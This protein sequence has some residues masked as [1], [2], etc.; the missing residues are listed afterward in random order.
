M[1]LCEE[2]DLG[3]S[4]NLLWG[5]KGKK[6]EEP[7]QYPVGFEPTASRVKAT[8]ACTLLLCYNHCPFLMESNFTR[9]AFLAP[10]PCTYTSLPLDGM[11]RNYHFYLRGYA[12]ACHLLCQDP[13]LSYRLIP[14]RK[15]IWTTLGSNPACQLHKRARYPLRH[16]LSGMW[17]A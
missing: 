13:F 17:K 4:T 2:P 7:S 12:R 15:T 14:E 3:L 9:K 10:I 6:E 8:E 1:H 5:E 16:C 11:A